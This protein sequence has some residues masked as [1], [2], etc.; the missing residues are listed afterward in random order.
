MNDNQ[1]TSK[2]LTTMVFSFLS[3]KVKLIILGVITVLLIIIFIPIIAIASLTSGDIDEETDSSQSVV[4]E[5]VTSD[6]T[7]KYINATFP[8]PFET[9]DG[10]KDVITSKFSKSRTIVVKGQTQTKAHTGI[11]LVVV[12][13]SSPRIASVYDGTV[14]VSKSGTT[15]YGNYVVIK[16]SIEDKTIYTLY[17]HM[18]EGSIMV[19]EGSTVTAGQI[20]GTMGSTGNSTGPHLHFEIRIGENSSNKAVDPY[21]YLFG[22]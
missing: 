16:H 11:D 21:P 4:G 9:W 8:M 10:S 6:S 5:V 12:S 20:L 18:K 2:D 13:K 19:A 22:N 17:G 7:Y 15:G 1:N 14:V 3:N